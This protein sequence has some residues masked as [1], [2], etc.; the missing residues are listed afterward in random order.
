A[1]GTRDKFKQPFAS[2]SVWNMPIGSGAAYRSSPIVSR[3]NFF[4]TAEEPILMGGGPLKDA[5]ENGDWPISGR[6]GGRKL[7]YQVPVP[8]GMTTHS[9]TDLGNQANFSGGFLKSDRRTLVEAPRLV[10]RRR[11][12]ATT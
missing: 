2:N 4:W 3:M 1:T 7:P 9:A 11:S 12:R 6:V 8:A 5:Y 10:V